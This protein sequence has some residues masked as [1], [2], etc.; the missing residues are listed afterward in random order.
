MV[1]Y[2]IACRDFGQLE[3][4]DISGLFIS[5]GINYG[6]EKD[7]IVIRDKDNLDEI[8]EARIVIGFLSDKYKLY[9]SK[10]KIVSKA[11]A[12]EELKKGVISNTIISLD[13][14]LELPDFISKEFLCVY[15]GF[16]G[17]NFPNKISLEKYLFINQIA[18]KGLYNNLK[19]LRKYS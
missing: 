1:E 6:V 15:E 9:F 12:A 17:K 3:R 13:E 8:K 4:K 18:F 19:V 7:L 14:N 5:G 11:E 10:R 2:N 16:F